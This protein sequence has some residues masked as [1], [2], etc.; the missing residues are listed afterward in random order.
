MVQTPARTIRCLAML[1]LALAG[2]MAAGGI[3]HAAGSDTR[4][5]TAEVSELA[6]RAADLVAEEQALLTD[7]TA[8]LT[9]LARVDA[10]GAATLVRL[11]RLGVEISQAARTS[12][13]RLPAT[14]AG[15]RPLGPPPVIYSAAIGD[16]Q[17]VAAT[18]DA[19]TAGDTNDG[20]RGNL[21]AIALGLAVGLVLILRSGALQDDDLDGDEPWFDDLDTTEW[22]DTLTGVA[23]RRRFERD[24]EAFALPTDG[25]TALLMV[26]VDGLS[27]I[28]ER[29]GERVGDEALFELAGLL[30]VNVRS[31]DVVYRYG[32]E[33]FCLL[34]LDATPE[35]AQAIAE[36]IIDAAHAIELPDGDRL[37]VSV[38]LAA[39]QAASL[40]ETF[41]W[42][43]RALLEAKVAGRDQVRRAGA[44]PVDRP[45]TRT[46][47]RRALHEVA[48]PY[49]AALLE[50]L[51]HAVHPEN[52]PTTPSAATA[53]AGD[54]T[55]WRSSSC[56][57]W[58]GRPPWGR[59]RLEQRRHEAPPAGTGRWADRADPGPGR[60]RRRRPG[61]GSSRPPDRAPATT[62]PQRGE[63]V[64]GDLARPHQVP[65]RRQQLGVGGVGGRPRGAVPRSS[66]PGASARAAPSW[67][68]P[69]GASRALPPV[70]ACASW[71]AKHSRTRPSVEPIAPAPTHTTSPAGAEL[72]EHRPAVAAPAPAA[73]RARAWTPRA[74]PPPA[75]RARRPAR[76]PR[77]SAGMPCHAGRKRASASG[78]TGSTSRRSAASDRR[79]SW[80][81]TSTSHHSRCTPSGP[82]LARTIRSA[83]SS[84]SSTAVMRCGHAP[85]RAPP[86]PR[87]RTVRGCGRSDPRALRAGAHRLGE[88]RGSPSGIAHPSAS[89]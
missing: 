13:S 66:R 40:Q 69:S 54:D 31:Q 15:Q 88:R 4:P 21:I 56:S 35:D 68:A 83:A 44:Q 89:R 42:A 14:A 9:D 43:D 53:L 27:E 2:T 12:L 16:L 23:S 8:S 32:G 19:V 26:D 22:N 47:P 30:A 81:S 10:E 5:I 51:E 25:P 38:G 17:R 63:R 28:N 77:R 59:H 76:R 3:T 61:P 71:S 87:S 73:R 48:A 55:P 78:S 74:A 41:E 33:E 65:Q 6:T 75:T 45:G 1:G 52:P 72:V 37:T 82:E 85:K 7:V 58:R 64:V 18:P 34:L 80:R 79:R 20:G 11:D 50:H 24:L 86:R 70:R 60:V 62:R 46:A 29:H 39:G 67:T 36:R 84:V 57:A 49:L